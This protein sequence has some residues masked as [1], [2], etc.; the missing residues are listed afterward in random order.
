[1]REKVVRGVGRGE[2]R[3]SRPPYNLGEKGKQRKQSKKGNEP[4]RS[5]RLGW[6]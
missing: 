5:Q 6:T 1:M 4:V 3:R 2:R